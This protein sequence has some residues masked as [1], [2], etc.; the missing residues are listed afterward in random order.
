MMTALAYPAI[1]KNFGSIQVDGLGEVFV[2]GPDWTGDFI[3]V[4]GNSFTLHGGGRIY[5][6]SQG[7]DELGPNTYLQIPLMDKHF[8]YTVDLSNVGCHCNAAGYFIGMPGA[9]PGDGGDWY[10]DA[11]FVGGQWCPEY[12]CLESNKYTVAGT[13]H[14]CSGD[15]SNW[16]ECDRGGCQSNAFNVDPNMFCPEDRCTINTQKPFLISHAQGTEYANI[17]MSQDGKEASFDICWDGGY[18]NNMAGSY[19]GMVF[20]ASLWGGPDIDM[21]WLD[22]MT[23]CGG[24][25]DIGGS[26]VTFSNFELW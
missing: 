14:T 8:A 24:T 9:G 20:S 4:S 21:G 18:C 5:F 10:C 7:T 12:D 1:A 15:G 13:L 2:I 22:G 11:N 26:S 3:T 19:G 6:G 16:W 17:W 25:C 23:G